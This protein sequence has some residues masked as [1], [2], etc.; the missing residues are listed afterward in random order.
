MSKEEGKVEYV[1]YDG[2]YPCL[3]S[4]T[5]LIKVDG[6]SYTLK[7][8]MISGGYIMGGPDTDWDM[9]AE[10]GEWDIDLEECP[11]LEPY[12]EEIIRVVNENVQ[13]GCCGGCI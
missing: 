9:W 10:Q 2:K 12:K 13:Y 4:G 6:K 11:E 5:L 1:S 8:A 3:C 7:H